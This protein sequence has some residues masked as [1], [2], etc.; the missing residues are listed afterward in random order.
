MRSG[1]EEL[2]DMRTNIKSYSKE[3]QKLIQLEWVDLIYQGIAK[4]KIENWQYIPYVQ[5][6]DGSQYFG[7]VK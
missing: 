2:C 3:M 5:Y 7:K 4:C 1:I 6:E